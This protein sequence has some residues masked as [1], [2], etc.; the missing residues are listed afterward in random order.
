MSRIIDIISK[1]TG[2]DPHKI[3]KITYDSPTN[4]KL[5]YIK[6]K[7][8]DSRA[9]FHP[10]KETKM[11]QYALM[12]KFLKKIP[13]HEFAMAYK[14][15]IKS[16]L[17]KNALYHLNTQYTLHIDFTNFFPSIIPEDFWRAVSV[18]FPG[19]EFETSDIELINNILFIKVKGKCFLSIGAPT[20]PIIS[21][22]V[23]K[24]MDAQFLKL[25]K[26][27]DEYS[28][29]TRYAD[30]I[31]ISTNIKG[32]SQKIYY[33]IKQH[34]SET[35]SP[36]LTI[37]EKKTYFLSKKGNR[38][39]TGLCITNMNS[40]VIPRNKK[41]IIRSLIH[42]ELTSNKKDKTRLSKIKGYLA[43]IKDIEPDFFNKLVIKFGDG[44]NDL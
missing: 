2:L 1:Y 20:S 40:V 35:E 7:N 31:N 28:V 21:N 24:E 27:L 14:K 22:I 16:P 38:L 42:T 37:N 18:A 33:S 8:G 3:L 36:K 13:V 32:F 25:C 12:E 30:D 6:K 41:R 11:L 5:Y 26:T 44:I 17:K 4:Y 10:S 43:F 15:G 29:Y 23:M 34:L 9:I 39:I 19:K